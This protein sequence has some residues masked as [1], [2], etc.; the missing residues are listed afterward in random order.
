MNF[1][2]RN[3]QKNDNPDIPEI[4]NMQTGA[5]QLQKCLE[6]LEKITR[7]KNTP[8]QDIKKQLLL[9]EQSMI[10]LEEYRRI[11]NEKL[12]Q[13]NVKNDE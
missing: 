3:R 6:K 11:I 10:L 8:Q 13:Q 5:Y 7:N 9:I 1:F 4:K 12:L 2:H